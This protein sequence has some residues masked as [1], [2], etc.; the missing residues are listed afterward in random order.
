M[1]A[2]GITCKDC[3][4]RLDL[5]VDEELDVAETDEIDAHLR[6]CRS[7]ASLAQERRQWKRKMRAAGEVSLSKTLRQRTCT[8]FKEV[9]QHQQRLEQRR[10]LGR[11]LRQGAGALALAAGVVI[12][13]VWVLG[14]EAPSG[15]EAARGAGMLAGASAISQPVVEVAVEWHRKPITVEVTGPHARSV[16]SWF[17]GQT[18]FHVH[19]P[20]FGR[21][22][23]LLGG[24]LGNVG[25]AQAAVLVY[26]MQGHKVSVL[27]FPSHALPGGPPRSEEPFFDNTGGYV[28]AL[29]ERQGLAYTF[30]SEM[31]EPMLRQLLSHATWGPAAVSAP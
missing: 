5:Y 15:P 7:C 30:T 31:P 8:R 24:R 10:R 20:D 3:L 21:S 14:T 19:V 16:Q 25:A 27:A 6:G 18:P 22:A 4:E 1:T 23:R 12:A 9:R 17:S 29:Q 28:V 13:G 2:H 11:R 26:E